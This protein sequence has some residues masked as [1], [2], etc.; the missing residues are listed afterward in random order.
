MHVAARESLSRRHGRSVD[1]AVAGIRRSGEA[2]DGGVSVD[3]FGAFDS[4]DSSGLFGPFGAR[5]PVR[6]GRAVMFARVVNRTR[7]LRDLS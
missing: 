2:G 5:S 6:C 7:R 1:R 3:S 4:F